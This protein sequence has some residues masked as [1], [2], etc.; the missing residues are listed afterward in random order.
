[1]VSNPVPIYSGDIVSGFEVPDT[2][3]TP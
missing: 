1:M 3:L 2:I